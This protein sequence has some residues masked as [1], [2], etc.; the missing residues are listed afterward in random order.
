MTTY[1]LD[2]SALLRLVDSEPGA[3]RIREILRAKT[4][5]ICRVEISPINWGEVTYNISK[6]SNH[7]NALDLALAIFSKHL[8]SSATTPAQAVRAGSLKTQYK[9]PYADAF[10]LELC[11]GSTERILVTADFDFKVASQD[12]RIEFL[13]AKPKL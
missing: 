10:A 7:R 9:I 13:P 6:R 3:E 4:L 5:G 11:S 1:I 2:S 8:I 12:F